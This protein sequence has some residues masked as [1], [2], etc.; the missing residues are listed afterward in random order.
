MNLPEI[1][2]ER[3]IQKKL[4]KKKNYERTK[5]EKKRRKNMT[6][7]KNPS[8]PPSSFFSFPLSVAPIT[9]YLNLL[10]PSI[11]QTS[12]H[13]HTHKPTMHNTLSS[14]LLSHHSFF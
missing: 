4:E 11:S 14:P 13:Y 2:I 9:T 10:L 7:K 5:K 12:H 3:N 8:H 1:G 6:R